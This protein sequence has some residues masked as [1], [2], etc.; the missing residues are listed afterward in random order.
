VTRDLQKSKPDKWGY[1]QA[2]EIWSPKEEAHVRPGHF[3]L[4]KLG[5]VDGSNSCVEKEFKL[6]PH[7]SEEYKGLRFRDGDRALVVDVWLHRVDEDVSG[8]TFE[9]WD[10]SVDSDASQAPVSMI[11]N[12]SDLRA[13]GFD[14]RDVIPLQLEAEARGGRCTRDT[15]LKQIHGMGT[16]RYVLSVD[17]DNEFRSRCE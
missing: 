10:P 17:N 2:R 14:L 11:V 6:G 5:K 4:M 15:T 7:K 12:S 3:W 16:K 13:A 8:L 9:E 1:V